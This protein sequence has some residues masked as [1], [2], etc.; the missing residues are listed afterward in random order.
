MELITGVD[1]AQTLFAGYPGAF[2]GVGNCLVTPAMG[3]EADV[4]YVNVDAKMTPPKS[5]V[6]PSLPTV[7]E[8]ISFLNG[9]L[10]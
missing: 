4:T 3:G 9:I 1:L 6:Y 5:C 10:E 2:L 8:S 7:T